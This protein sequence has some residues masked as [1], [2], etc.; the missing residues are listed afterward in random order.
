MPEFAVSSGIEIVL[1]LTVA[2]LVFFGSA[3]D[4]HARTEAKNGPCVSQPD[5]FSRYKIAGDGMHVFICGGGEVTIPREAHEDGFSSPAMSRDH[6][7]VG[8]LVDTRDDGVPDP[9]AHTLAIYDS[10]D[11]EIRIS[12]LDAI[13]DWRFLS[14]GKVAIT[15][16]PLHF[17]NPV[18]EI[19]RIE[20][21]SR[22]EVTQ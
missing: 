4:S 9:I 6:K 11:N 10:G 18:E 16:G 17:S 1:R 19:Y 14:D 15:S 12:K 13:R 7:K 2:C 5:G 3:V 20:P 8:W 22:K 21:I